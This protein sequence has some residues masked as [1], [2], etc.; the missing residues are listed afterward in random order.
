MGM[1]IFCIFVHARTRVIP[2]GTLQLASTRMI[3][4]GGR[5][6]VCVRVMEKTSTVLSSDSA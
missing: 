2:S 5:T 1:Y 6:L 4:T 3:Q